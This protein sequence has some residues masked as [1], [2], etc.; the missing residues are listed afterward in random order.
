MAMMSFAKP[1]KNCFPWAIVEMAWSSWKLA[2]RRT[3]R[4]PRFEDDHQVGVLA[5]GADLF[6][7]LGK[8]GAGEKFPLG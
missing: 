5:E 1:E 7:E 3:D 4:S 2:R 8:Q 6:R